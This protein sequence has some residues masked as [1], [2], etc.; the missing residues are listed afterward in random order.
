L[1]GIGA[2]LQQRLRSR[3]DQ[4]L[5]QLQENARAAAIGPGC[6]DLVLLPELLA[7]Q[8]GEQQLQAIA[9]AMATYT[10]SI[11]ALHATIRDRR[12]VVQA[13]LKAFEAL[14]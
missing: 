3:L 10:A 1:P 9:P 5:Q 12:S 4:V 8:N 13:Q 2:G 14:C 11:V 7:L 6:D